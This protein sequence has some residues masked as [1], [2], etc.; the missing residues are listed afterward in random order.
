M[1]MVSQGKKLC[2]PEEKEFQTGF[3]LV[4]LSTAGMHQFA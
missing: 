4:Q 2:N 3:E 1:D